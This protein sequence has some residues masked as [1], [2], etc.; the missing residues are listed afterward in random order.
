MGGLPPASSQ[1]LSNM[2]QLCYIAQNQHDY[3]R[4]FATFVRDNDPV[5]TCSERAR[6]TFKMHTLVLLRAMT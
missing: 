5:G 6:D 2:L 4:V 3:I 1:A